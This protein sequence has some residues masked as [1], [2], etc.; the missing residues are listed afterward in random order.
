MKSNN[1][2]AIIVGII[3]LIVMFFFP[4]PETNFVYYV[5]FIFLVIEVVV[6]LLLKK[7]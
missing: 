4:E 2:F 1:I 6:W 5:G 3:G 7:S